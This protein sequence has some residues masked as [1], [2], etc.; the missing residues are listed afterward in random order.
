MGSKDEAEDQLRIG[1]LLTVG[2]AADLLGVH[3]NTVRDWGRKGQLA[4]I[5]VGSRQDRRYRRRD[6]LALVQRPADDEPE[7]PQCSS[8]R[9]PG[10]VPPLGS[11]FREPLGLKAMRDPLAGLRS[12]YNVMDQFSQIT[13]GLARSLQGIETASLLARGFTSS[14]AELAESVTKL[15][16]PTRITPVLPPLLGDLAL[17]PRIGDLMVGRTPAIEKLLTG[18][19]QFAKSMAEVAG[20]TPPRLA[21]QFMEGILPA[22]RAL[23]TIAD[24][25]RTTGVA[26]LATEQAY[27]SV[28]AYQSFSTGLFGKAYGQVEDDFA[29]SVALAEFRVAGSI[30]DSALGAIKGLGRFGSPSAEDL[31]LQLPHPTIYRWLETEVDEQREELARLEPEQIDAELEQ[32][33]ALQISRTATRII[34]ARHACNQ[35]WQLRG[36]EPIFKPTNNTEFVS[37]MLP[38]WVAADE[39]QFRQFIDW[40]FKYVYESS[41]ELKR[42]KDRIG[43]PPVTMTIK[44]LR[45][46]YFHDLEHGETKEIARKHK[47][48]GDEFERL[49][50]VATI[51][52][53]VQW[54]RA[55]LAIL[56]EVEKLLNDLNDHL[57]FGSSN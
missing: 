29:D 43:I 48:V 10:V 7:L 41:G 24:I 34:Q 25:T 11:A 3:P 54:Q 56:R 36:D 14:R 22:R 40:M 12:M 27:L 17:G 39:A 4:E 57:R 47:R 9:L 33:L 6:V 19:Q 49:V 13:G 35:Q 55:Q 30:L 38:Q 23:D 31:G 8:G 2:Q 52:T 45:H 44:F 51:Q 5:R 53:P 46:F 26:S 28:N 1:E 20:W 15:L 42:L 18:H 50:G 21:D 37:G 32:T 16:E